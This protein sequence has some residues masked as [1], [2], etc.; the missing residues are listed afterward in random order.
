MG[1]IVEY[2]RLFHR[3]I[4]ESPAHGKA[5]FGSFIDSCYDHCGA[6]SDA[7][8][9]NRTVQGVRM[10]DAVE[11]W[12]N[13]QQ[14]T[15]ESNEESAGDAAMTRDAGDGGHHYSDCVWSEPGKPCNPT[16]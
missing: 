13:A 8:M 1:Q 10:K 12:W 11:L 6:M 3:T 15:Q 4:A 2:Q 9:V 7:N 16:C 5:G 14:P